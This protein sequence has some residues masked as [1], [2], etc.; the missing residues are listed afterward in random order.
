MKLATTAMY[1]YVVYNNTLPTISTAVALRENLR[2][3]RETIPT[4]ERAP[5][6]K[7]LTS[8]D[9]LMLLLVL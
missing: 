4:P 2:M 8:L 5:L 7:K 1:K 3:R 6:N 9:H